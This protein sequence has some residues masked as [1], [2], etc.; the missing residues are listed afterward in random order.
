MWV[1]QDLFTLLLCFSYYKQYRNVCP[2]ECTSELI[3][4]YNEESSS[5]VFFNW[6][7]V[8]L[9]YCV[10]FRYTA[11]WFRSIHSFF[12]VKSLTAHSF[13]ASHQ[14]L[15]LSTCGEDDGKPMLS[16]PGYQGEG[17][18]MQPLAHPQEPSSQSH[19][20][21]TIK[22]Q[23]HFALLSQCT[24]DFPG[25]LP[26]VPRKPHCVSNELF[27]LSQCMCGS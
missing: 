17:H 25:S 18:T 20:L 24:S 16:L 1:D 12:R 8:G 2:S 10:S 23:T 7:I 14:S 9:Q 11:K 3:C 13:Q 27:I 5:T 6:S 21:T 4:K 19:P 15:L 26:Y 22:T